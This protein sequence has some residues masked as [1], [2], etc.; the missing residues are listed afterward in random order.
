M[1]RLEI[2]E[3]Y[4]ATVRDPAKGYDELT[5]LGEYDDT[6]IKGINIWGDAVA[7]QLPITPEEFEAG[8]K[9]RLEGALMQVAFPQLEERHREFLMSGTDTCNDEF[10]LEPNEES[11]ESTEPTEPTGEG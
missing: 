3:I 6:L 4:R 10:W 1:N 5:G 7:M 8:M 9:L 11:T 2:T